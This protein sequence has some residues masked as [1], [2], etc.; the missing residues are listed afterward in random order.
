MSQK[1]AGNLI[2]F[3]WRKGKILLWLHFAG[4]VILTSYIYTQTVSKLQIT[5]FTTAD[6][7]TFV[8]KCRIFWYVVNVM[9]NTFVCLH[10]KIVDIKVAR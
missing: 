8:N 9:Q 6:V 2:V 10:G 1:L 4:F 5:E 3:L 7:K